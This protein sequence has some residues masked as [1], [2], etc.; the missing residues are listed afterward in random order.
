MRRKEQPRG[1]NEIRV[2]S[3]AR[4]VWLGR[5]EIR[6]AAI[7]PILVR[8]PQ[9]TRVEPF[10]RNSPR[11]E[12]SPNPRSRWQVALG[13]GSRIPGELVATI[14]ISRRNNHIGN[15]SSKVVRC[16]SA[17]SMIE[18]KASPLVVTDNL[19]E[20]TAAKNDYRNPRTPSPITRRVSRLV[21]V[22]CFETRRCFPKD[23]HV[24][25]RF[26]IPNDRHYGHVPHE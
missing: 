9:A 22:V 7:D 2:E 16:A 19:P 1:S 11:L 20:P 5:G 6:L 8:E 14:R 15:C 23:I 3:F 13:R 17:S 25:T 18:S 24:N 21:L 4:R 10:G 12:S 26:A